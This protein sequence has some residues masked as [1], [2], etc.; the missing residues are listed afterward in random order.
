MSSLHSDWSHDT[1]G[2]R[3]R[4]KSLL[5]QALGL[6]AA[7][8][9][10][11]AAT[12]AR[13]AIVS[14]PTFQAT[15]G[16]K[17]TTIFDGYQVGVV[18]TTSLF[19]LPTGTTYLL[20]GKVTDTPIGGGRVKTTI[21]TVTPTYILGSPLALGGL[22]NDGVVVFTGAANSFV[23][24]SFNNAF[25]GGTSYTEGE[26]KTYIGSLFLDPNATD[27]SAY[28]TFLNT[29]TGSYS[30]ASGVTPTA[31]LFSGGQNIGTVNTNTFVP[32]VLGGQ[33]EGFGLAPETSPAST[34]EPSQVAPFAFLGLGLGGLLLRARSR[35]RAA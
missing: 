33:S 26:V 21:T 29:L 31:Y 32:G 24:E 12:P 7:A 2:N 23:G 28:D 22:A 14:I 11:A 6:A 19:S 25:L 16:G 10:L 1:T 15:S 35:R 30:S 17:T 27:K 3:L 9:G 34:P 5:P 20:G 18:T 4:R 13:A 8:L